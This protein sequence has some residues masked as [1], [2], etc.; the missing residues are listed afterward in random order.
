MKPEAALLYL[1]VTSS[2]FA[3]F[4]AGRYLADLTESGAEVT[5]W[6]GLAGS[7]AVGVIAVL[8]GKVLKKELAGASDDNG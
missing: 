2:G 4:T 7:V 5:D 3:F 8:A 6:I 1:F